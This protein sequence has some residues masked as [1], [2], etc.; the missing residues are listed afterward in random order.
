MYIYQKYILK[1]QSSY[2]K[3]NNIKL[4]IIQLKILNISQYFKNKTS[5]RKIK[6][7]TTN[8]S[9]RENKKM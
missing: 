6:N 3:W 1:I 4:I 2:S 7:K 8:E 9:Q 5:K